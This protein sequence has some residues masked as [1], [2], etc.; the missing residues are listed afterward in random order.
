MLSVHAGRQLDGDGHLTL[1]KNRISE[2]RAW[3]SRY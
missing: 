1:L 3:L 2:V